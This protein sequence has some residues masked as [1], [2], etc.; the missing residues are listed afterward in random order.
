MAAKR[1][2]N[3]RGWLLSHTMH[4]NTA[5]NRENRFENAL[6]LVIRAIFLRADTDLIG[7]LPIRASAFSTLLRKQAANRTSPDRA[8]DALKAVRCGLRHYPHV[9][10]SQRVARTRARCQAPRSNP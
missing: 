4:C 7:A 9:I 5:K 6:E 1:L 8:T 2:I 10:A 3:Q